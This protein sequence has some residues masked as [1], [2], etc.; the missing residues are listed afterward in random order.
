MSRD[1][2]PKVEVKVP[3]WTLL[4]AIGAIGTGAFAWLVARFLD[5]QDQILELHKILIDLDRMLNS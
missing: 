5:L 3:L 2:S 1:T 4:G